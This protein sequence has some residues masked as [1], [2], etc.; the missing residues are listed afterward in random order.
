MGAGGC[1]CRKTRCQKKYCECHSKGVRCTAKCNCMDC[2]NT[3]PQQTKVE[4]SPFA[5][6]DSFCV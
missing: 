1:N 2:C 4:E 3:E 6:I 5:V